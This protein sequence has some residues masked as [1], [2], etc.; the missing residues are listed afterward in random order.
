M[1]SSEEK[2]KY[3]ALVIDIDAGVSKQISSAVGKLGFEPTAHVSDIKQAKN[4]LNTEK[5]DFLFLDA[6]MPGYAALT[7]LQII[8]QHK[9]PEVRTIPI[10]A[11]LGKVNQ[12]D[13]NV[14]TELGVLYVLPKPLQEHIVLRKVQAMLVDLSNPESMIHFEMNFRGFLARG[15]FDAAIDAVKKQLEANP[16]SGRL[17]L[18]LALALYAAKRT[19][20]ALVQ[21]QRVLQALPKSAQ[22]LTLAG[23]LLIR[24]KNI[25][26]AIKYLEMAHAQCPFSVERLLLM[27]ELLTVAGRSKLGE[28]RFRMALNLCP[29]SELARMGVAKSL[30]TQGDLDNALALVGNND[31][32]KAGLISHLNLQ[33]VLLSRVGRF[34]DAV[35]MYEYALRFVTTP[36]QAGSVW[37][38]LALAQFKA[39]KLEKSLV[40][41]ERALRADPSN[42]KVGRLKAACKE[43][44]ASL[45]AGAPAADGV[46]KA[47]E[48]AAQPAEAAQS[49]SKEELPASMT[50]SDEYLEL[51]DTGILTNLS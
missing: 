24:K 33:G 19:D 36:R 32:H 51:V 5:F 16:K 21:V 12:T 31:A 49:K 23:K 28:Q 46:A 38:N 42:E 13:L 37:Y 7:L 39:N 18:N 3:R 26:A 15:E 50:L 14:L 2:R 6:N 40:S 34:G 45:A 35:L 47:G 41:C 9:K 48:A 30:V 29:E 11:T 43:K 4:T 17:H 44:Q 10:V 8:S 27:G 25:M 1:S 22:A 20:E